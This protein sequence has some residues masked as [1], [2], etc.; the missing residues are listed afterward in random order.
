MAHCQNPA[1]H[2]R[3]VI[4]EDSFNPAKPCCECDT[5]LGLQN[6]GNFQNWNPTLFATLHQTQSDC[7]RQ[8]SSGSCCAGLVENTARWL[9]SVAVSDKRS[10]LL[11][12]CCGLAEYKK[13]VSFHTSERRYK[14]QSE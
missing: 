4:G 6:Y 5:K 2:A 9:S 10:A 3:D 11:T 13:R 1:P 8:V 12:V 14:L 7:I